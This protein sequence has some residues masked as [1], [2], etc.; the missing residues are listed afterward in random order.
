M[1]LDKTITHSLNKVLPDKFSKVFIKC[2]ELKIFNSKNGVLFSEEKYCEPYICWRARR[3]KS[4][5]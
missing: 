4:L 3:V 2:L 5:P 1:K